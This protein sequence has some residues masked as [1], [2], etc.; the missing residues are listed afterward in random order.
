MKAYERCTG[1]KY[2]FDVEYKYNE[3]Y[4]FDK[5]RSMSNETIQYICNLLNIKEMLHLE[6]LWKV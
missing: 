4:C 5:F 1:I 2:Y 6:P 3:E